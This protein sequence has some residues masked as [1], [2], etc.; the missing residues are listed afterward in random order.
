M[1][2]KRYPNSQDIDENTIWPPLK[3]NFAY[4]YVYSLVTY[5]SL[6]LNEGIQKNNMCTLSVTIVFEIIDVE[7]QDYTDNLHILHWP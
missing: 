2:V 3:S 7:G 5:H 6:R 4:V 1:N